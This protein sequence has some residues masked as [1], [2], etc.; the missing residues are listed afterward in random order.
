MYAR[1]MPLPKP[2]ASAEAFPRERQ[3]ENPRQRR[4]KYENPGSAR[5]GGRERL[6]PARRP[7]R[8]K[9]IKSRHV[10]A[11]STL[12]P[13]LTLTR[14]VDRVRAEPSRAEPSRRFEGR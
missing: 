14:L 1:R 2:D 6:A 10:I 12:S 4:R 8:L 11:S 5:V 3:L 9:S 7:P 13:P